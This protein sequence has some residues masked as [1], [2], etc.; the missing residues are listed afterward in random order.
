MNQAHFELKAAVLERLRDQL[1]AIVD[2][3]WTAYKA[4]WK[5]SGGLDEWEVRY[6]GIRVKAVD[7][8]D[9]DESWH[10]IPTAYFYGTPAERAEQTASAKAKIAVLNAAQVEKLRRNKVAQL[11]AQL[12]ELRGE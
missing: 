1:D 6:D 7:W 8:R 2:A 12:R 11:E 10:T 4:D 3:A 9:N 5:L